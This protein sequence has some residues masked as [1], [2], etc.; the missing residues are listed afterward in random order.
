MAQLQA[1]GR[2]MIMKADGIFIGS[3][4]EFLEESIH[5]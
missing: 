3:W 4:S 2:K 1:A 5:E